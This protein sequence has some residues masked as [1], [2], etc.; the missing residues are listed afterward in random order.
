MRKKLLV[1]A[2]LLPLVFMSPNAEA[3]SKYEVRRLKNGTCDV[4]K[5]RPGPEPGDRVA[6][7]FDS[8]E[9]AEK[10]LRELKSTPRCK[11]F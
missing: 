6:G 10:Q 3:S 8:K 4:S 2:A 1:V 5:A 9:R 7:P 11:R